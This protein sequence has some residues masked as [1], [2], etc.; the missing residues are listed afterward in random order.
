MTQS[1]LLAVG[2]ARRSAGL[3]QQCRRMAASVQVEVVD[4]AGR[5]VNGA[6]AFLES[7]AASADQAHGE[8]E[9]A[10]Q[11][12]RFLPGVLVVPVGT[13]VHFPNRD[14]VRHHVYLVSPQNSSSSSTPARPPIPW[15]LTGRAWSPWVVT[16]TT[17]WWAGLWWWT[18]RTTRPLPG[19]RTGADQRRAAGNHKAARLA[20]LHG[21]G[22]ARHEQ[23]VGA[24]HRQCA[25]CDTLAG[26]RLMWR[27]LGRSLIPPWWCP[28]CCC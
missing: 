1:A 15:C 3:F 13:S 22:A 25:R 20:P 18:R 14:S 2:R 21:T 12:K 28:C 6:V 23:P 16:S 27:I 7:A 26:W 10:Q 8:A 11:D 17:A 9:M 4:E 5:P 19:R 24:C